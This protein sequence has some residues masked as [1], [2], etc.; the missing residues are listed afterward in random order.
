[1]NE[2]INLVEILKDCKKGTKFY[3][4]AYGDLVLESVCTTVCLNGYPIVFTMLS[5]PD[6]RYMFTKD[7]R[8]CRNGNGECCIFP[9]SD[10]RDWSKFRTPIEKFNPKEFKPF[11]RVLTRDFD[12][13]EWRANLFSHLQKINDSFYVDCIGGSWKMCVP[14][15]ELTQHLIGTNKDCIDFYKWWENNE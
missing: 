12:N 6:V 4:S 1:M 5:R 2:N 9:S 11:D 13:Q 15:N 3:S 7:G 10:Q 14:Y 8:C